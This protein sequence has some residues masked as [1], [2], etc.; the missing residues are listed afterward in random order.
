MNLSK[1]I[2]SFNDS[3][4]FLDWVECFVLPAYLLKMSWIPSYLNL[5][6]WCY[7]FLV[8]MSFIKCIAI[9]FFIEATAGL[10]CYSFSF[11][12]SSSVGSKNKMSNSFSMFFI[13][14]YSFYSSSKYILYSL[15]VSTHT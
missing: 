5:S 11:T 13:S 4:Y 12:I 1:Y 2:R 6:R 7:I 8:S 3:E 15:S 14:V 10:N 9:L